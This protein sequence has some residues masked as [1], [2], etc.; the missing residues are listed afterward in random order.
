MSVISAIAFVVC[1][2]F[3]A[4]LLQIDRAASSGLSKALWL[5]SVWFLYCATRPLNEWFLGGQYSESGGSSIE[6]GSVVDRYFLTVLLVIGLWVLSRRGIN[7]PQA[8]RNNFWLFA[9][10]FFM[11]V[12]ILWSDYPFVSLKRW[13]RTAG[14]AVMA[15]VILSEAEPYEAILAVIRRTMYLVIPFSMLLVKYYP[16]LG[17]SYGHS[18]GAPMYSGATL[19]KNTLGEICVL[20]VFLFIW[21]RFAR[22]DNEDGAPVVR[23]QKVCELV[24]LAMVFFLMKGP[25]GYGAR[26]AS[27]SATSIVVLLMG[28]GVFFLMRRY[29][30]S[31]AQL[32]GRVALVLV[33]SGL[34]TLVLFM[35]GTSPMAVGAGLLGR[36]ANLTG[37]SDQIWPLLAPIAWH[38]PV[39][40]LGYGA[41]WINVSPELMVLNINEAHNGY[42]DV[43]IELGGVGLILVLLV[44][45]TYF[46]KARLELQENFYWAAF[47]MSYLVMF[48]VHNWTET[49][50]LR[51]RETLWNLFVVFA[52]VY[53]QEWTDPVAEAR[54]SAEESSSEVEERDSETDAVAV[55]S[56]SLGDGME[57]AEI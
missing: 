31:L 55:G 12:S 48:L 37:R 14:T 30:T 28:L 7:W 22:R 19:T 21:S 46:R 57:N 27:Y 32:G 51:S 9:L 5:P 11:L 4:K 39:L 36:E 20:Y 17:V 10:L 33:C 53:P 15:L 35:L 45:V 40:G 29:R 23:G 8:M 43:L 25:S 1:V 3:V 41:F 24:L 13:V 54:L 56:Q 38:N 49:T 50:L 42:L 2:I 44:I 16:R 6:S 26:A 52:V 34:V 18:S 47:R